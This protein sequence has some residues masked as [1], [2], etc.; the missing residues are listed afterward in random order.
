MR[1]QFLHY[2]TKPLPRTETASLLARIS[3]NQT[4]TLVT[5]AFLSALTALFQSAGGFFP[6]NI[7]KYR[8]AEDPHDRLLF[9]S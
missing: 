1:D 2:W 9:L 4:K 8:R 5:I 7:N 6:G 3:A